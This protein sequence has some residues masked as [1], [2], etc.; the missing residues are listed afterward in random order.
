M[1][2][3]DEQADALVATGRERYGVPV[4]PTRPHRRRPSSVVEGQ[5]DIPLAEVRAAWSATLPA[6]LG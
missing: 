6:A 3:P 4:T 5:F 1:T 2:V